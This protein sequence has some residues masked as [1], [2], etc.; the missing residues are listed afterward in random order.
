ADGL[1][2]TASQRDDAE[3]EASRSAV[4]EGH[5]EGVQIRRLAVGPDLHGP[6]AVVERGPLHRQQRVTPSL[7][8]QPRLTCVG[9]R[10][11]DALMGHPHVDPAGAQKGVNAAGW[12]A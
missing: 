9:A 6:P 1:K 7:S 5:L 12:E 2:A 11:P 10:R 4:D 3:P 8:E